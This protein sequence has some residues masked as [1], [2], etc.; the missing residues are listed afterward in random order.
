MRLCESEGAF[1]FEAY[2]ALSTRVSWDEAQRISTALVVI[3]DERTD[4]IDF[5]SK[6]KGK[7]FAPGEQAP[8][9]PELTIADY[10][11][12]LAECTDALAKTTAKLQAHRR[13]LLS[14]DYGHEDRLEPRDAAFVEQCAEISRD[15]I[16]AINE[17]LARL[18]S[19]GVSD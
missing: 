8:E 3:G 7:S 4:W 13:A 14:D 18:R 16:E 17:E 5:S 2:H 6:N 19:E 9:A 15:K 1:D 10:E 12:E 11:R